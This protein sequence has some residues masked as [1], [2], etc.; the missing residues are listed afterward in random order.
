MLR[1][2][3]GKRYLHKFEAEE[4]A[5]VI[6]A[7][8]IALQDPSHKPLEAVTGRKQLPRVEEPYTAYSHPRSFHAGIFLHGGEIQLSHTYHLLH[9]RK[10]WCIIMR[11]LALCL[12]EFARIHVVALGRFGLGCVTAIAPFH[13]NYAGEEI[14]DIAELMWVV[15]I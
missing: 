4:L 15:H 14:D 2:H 3:Y 10:K 11:L 8:H 7:T 1:A 9:R 12:E 13:M 6:G 5:E